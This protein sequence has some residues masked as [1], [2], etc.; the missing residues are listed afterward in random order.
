[1]AVKPSTQWPGQTTPP[2]ASYPYGGAQNVAV[3][4]DNTGTPWEK[5]YINDIWGFLQ[6]ILTNAGI[7][8]NELPETALLSQYLQG[9]LYLTQ[10]KPGMIKIFAG[11]VIPDGFLVADGAAVSRVVYADLFAVI[12]TFYGA[13]DGLTTFNLP[14]VRGRFARFLDM[15]AGIDPNA[16][17]RTN[18]GDGVT[19]D[20]VGTKQAGQNASHNHIAG[21][22]FTLADVVNIN[23]YGHSATAGTS[24]SISTQPAAGTNSPLTSTQGGLEA[25][26]VNI[27]FIGLIKY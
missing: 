19:G 22:N 15:G 17:T 6:A 18:R 10:E 1:M 26:P 3:I 25:R 13:G 4:G 7:V 16:A 27:A 11:S 14:D 20:N 5:D 2:S 12:G 9:L 24:R 23:S 21:G 8:P